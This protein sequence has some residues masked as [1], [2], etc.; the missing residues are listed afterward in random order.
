M[1]DAGL[2]EQVDRAA[3]RAGV[4]RAS[5]LTGAWALT[6]GYAGGG[7]EVVFGTTLS[8]RPATLPGVERMVGLFINTVPVRVGID[9]DARVSQWLQQLHGQQ[10]ERARLGAA[11]LTDIRRWAGYE[12]GELLS[13]LFVVENY[14]VNRQLARGDAGFDVSEFA[15][16]ETRTIIRWSAS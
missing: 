5:L 15:A 13:S 11:S 4:T 3:R 1:F 9:D 10:S 2:N 7:R 8:G 6:L 16:A 12:G 14:P